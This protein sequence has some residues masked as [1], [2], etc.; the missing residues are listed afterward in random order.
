MSFFCAV[1]G[2]RKS[3]L[4]IS[5]RLFIPLFLYLPFALYSANSF[6]WHTN[7]INDYKTVFVLAM[8]NPMMITFALI[9]HN[10][11]DIVFKLLLIMSAV[12]VII[13]GHAS[14]TNNLFSSETFVQVFSI[15]EGSGTEHQ[16][17]NLY[18]GIFLILLWT[19]PF[20]RRNLPLYFK[21]AAS[22]VVLALMFATGGR[23]AIVGTILILFVPLLLSSY[24]RRLKYISVGI[25]GLMVLG[26]ATNFFGLLEN[27]NLVGIQRFATIF[28][29]DDPSERMFLFSNAIDLF[30]LN[31]KNVIF[32]AGMNYFP[33]FIGA[34]RTGMYPHNYILELLSEY[35]IIGFTLFM[36]PVFYILS[37][38]KR[39]LGSFFGRSAFEKTAL[40]IFMF[41][42]IVRMFSGGLVAS[43]DLIFFLFLL[44]PG[45]SARVTG[46]APYG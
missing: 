19:V 26:V 13:V 23:S 8:V 27:V 31:A 36:M 45:T 33:V 11:K 29:K 30:M 17:I 20:L 44:Y 40:Y 28:N 35:G 15:E 3:R 14:L 6:V 2:Y 21:I 9:Y 41:F 16:N 4:N 39:I 10:N 25:L 34:W 46:S 7:Y 43:Y 24:S 1:V 18:L 37:L 22:P 42:V 12:Y 32:G 5:M 38:R